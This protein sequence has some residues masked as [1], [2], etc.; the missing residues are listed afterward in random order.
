MHN[1]DLVDVWFRESFK[2]EPRLTV[3]E[4]ADEHRILSKKSS[5]EPGRWRTERTPYLKEIMDCLSV[6]HPA[7]E[8]VFKKASQVGGTECGNNWLGYIVDHTPGPVMFV[9]PTV[10]LSKRNSRLRIEPL[11]E[12]SPK[13]KEKVRAHRSKDSANTL[14]QKDFDGGTLV[15]TGANSAVGLRSMPARFVMLDEI[16]GYPHDVDGEGDP[17]SLVQARSRTFTRRKIFKVS[18]PTYEG[19]SKIDDEWKLSDQRLY[20][21]PCPHCNHFQKLDFKNLQWE[22]NNPKSVLYYCE[23]CGVGIEE[24]YKTKFLAEGKWVPQNVGSPVVGF[25]LNSLYSPIGWYSWSEIARDYEKAKDKLEREKKST[26]MKSFTNT[27][28]GEPWKEPGEAPEWRRLYERRE[29]YEIGVCPKGVLFLTAGVDVQ[30]DR[31]EVEVVGWGKNKESWSVAH[32]VFSGD[33]ANDDVWK[34]LQEYLLSTFKT[35]QGH[36]LPIKMTAVD[37]GFNTQKVYNFTRLFSINKVVAIKGS[38]TLNILVGLPRIVDAKLKGKVNRRAA[39]FWNIGV[40]LLKSELYGWLK[41]DKAIGEEQTPHGFC[42]FP[43]YDEEYF[44]QLTAERVVQKQDRRGFVVHEWVKERERNE[45]LDCRIY[46]RAAASMAGLDRF[47]D[48]DFER[49]R[50]QTI[51]KPTESVDNK[52]SSIQTDRDGIKKKKRERSDFWEGYD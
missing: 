36:E 11:I 5:S 32:Q 7:K 40:N 28:L 39:R 8:I 1:L 22:P 14:L 31:L 26:L 20:L 45:V 49:F 16:D 43:E 38:D 21:I 33:T 41:M 37:S 42:H 15:M 47:R 2:P 12:E 27:V 44:K 46:A 13:L 52:L 24:R 29:K 48:R 10:E 34:K 3:S 50:V 25:F 4:W 18:T 9:Q 23:E 35:D 19:A 17:V 51:A 30:K 6:T